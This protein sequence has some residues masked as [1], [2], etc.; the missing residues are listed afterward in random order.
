MAHWKR[1]H[2]IT[3]R[4][5]SVRP[6]DPH[7]TLVG[8]LL[9]VGL[10]HLH[11]VAPVALVRHPER[12]PRPVRRP[13]GGRADFSQMGQLTIVRSVRADHEQFQ[14]VAHRE[15][16]DDLS[17]VGR[18][19]RERRPHGAGLADDPRLVPAVEVHH[20]H[21]HAAGDVA[22]VDDLRPVRRDRR[23]VPVAQHRQARPVGADA[24]HLG[25]LAVHAEDDPLAILRL[26]P[27]RHVAD[28]LRIDQPSDVR[29]VGVHHVQVRGAGPVGDERDPLPIGR[30]AGIAVL[31]PG[32]PRQV[33]RVPRFRVD[34]EHLGVARSDRRDQERPPGEVPRRGDGRG[35][36]RDQGS[37]FGLH[38]DRLPFA[39]DP[40]R[41]S[42]FPPPDPAARNPSPRR[43]APAP[44]PGPPRGPAA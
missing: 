21:A 5:R 34:R 33:P 10:L 16:V 41:A 19:V 11:R 22:G 40:R 6:D 28:R 7:R 31:R 38:V 17:P 14:G 13:R 2:S 43:P 37:K 27:A 29:P 20:E 35:D 3:L 12:D 36:E 39:V 26:S 30:P 4:I 15:R 23:V 24:G 1:R 44:N 9:G 8:G 42:T 18:P 25:A 32:A